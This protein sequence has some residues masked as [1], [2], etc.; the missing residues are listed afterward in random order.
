MAELN[1]SISSLSFSPDAPVGMAAVRSPLATSTAQSPH[2]QSAIP[3]PAR[4]G[5]VLG[6]LGVGWLIVLFLTAIFLVYAPQE[7][8]PP[9]VNVYDSAIMDIFEERLKK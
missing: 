9:L 2:P 8:A 1:S 6:C 5:W 3:K 7:E 4:I